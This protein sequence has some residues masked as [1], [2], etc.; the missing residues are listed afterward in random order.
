MN[1]RFYFATCQIGSEK[2]LKTEVLTRFPQLKFAFSRPGFITFKQEDG[3]GRVIPESTGIFTRLWGEILGQAKEPIALQALL[4]QIPAGAILHA[5]ERDEVV[6]GDEPK[7]WVKNANID[8]FVKG[9]KLNV[10]LNAEPEFGEPVYDLIWVDDFHVFLGKHLHGDHLYPAP[11]N[12]PE[13]KVPDT[14]PSRAYAKIAEAVMRFKPEVKKGNQVLEVGCSPGGA[15]TCMLAWG[16]VVTGVDPKEMD[17][18]VMKDPNFRFIQRMAKQIIPADLKAMNPDWLV[19]DMNIAP[20]EAIDEMGIVLKALRK[21]HDRNLFLKYGFLTL[22]LNDWK[23]AES[24]PLYM[25]RIQELG[26]EELY[27]MQLASNR[28]EFFVFA[29]GFH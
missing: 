10:R 22:K 3:K 25:K 27:P 26:F 5:F 20:L 29:K 17:H 12:L 1:P 16:M 11:G 4:T 15:T 23:F 28:Q 21:A 9:Q 7:G 6:P 13:V 19:M 8:R 24:I 2:A 14:S 18:R